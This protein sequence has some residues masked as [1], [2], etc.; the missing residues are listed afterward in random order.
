MPAGLKLSVTHLFNATERP[1]VEASRQIRA[2]RESDRSD[3]IA[4]WD[5]VFAEDPPWNAPA[6]V[7]DRKLTVQ[8][9]L[10][11]VCERE[12]RV[13]ATLL[14]GY[15]GFRGWVHHVA[16]AP[17]S[18]RQGVATNLMRAAEA[19][20]AELGCPKL[21]LQIRATNAAAV[22]F[23]E[24]VGYSAEERVSMGKRLG[25]WADV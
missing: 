15:D 13:V 3:V 1:E 6:D 22:K 10:F 19:G 24:S 8:P 21:N 5:R 9:H 4:L 11:F 12:Q 2:F 25:H 14:A 7:I 23:Y 18:Q 17:E 16:V 20:L